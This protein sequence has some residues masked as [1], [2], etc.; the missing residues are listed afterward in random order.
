M[1]NPRIFHID[2]SR[3]WRGGQR[4]VAYLMTELKKSNLW[5]HLVC[6]PGSKLAEFCKTMQLSFSEILM[7]GE[8][9]FISAYKISKL[10]IKFEA[11]ILHVHTAHGLSIGLLSKLFYPK[12]KLIYTK[13][14]AYQMK[15]N[16]MSAFKYRN[17]YLNK[18]VCISEYIRNSMKDQGINEEK[19][20]VIPSGIILPEVQP[21]DKSAFK[22]KYSI[23]QN[24]FI[25][26][27]I[28]SLE[29]NKGY[30]NL[31]NAAQYVLNHDKDI[32][33]LALGKG[34][35]EAELRKKVN[36]MGLS[37]HF[38]FLGFQEDTLSFLHISD[39]FVLPSRE[40]GLG[41]SILDAQA[42]GVPVIATK[43]GGIPEL[44][45][46]NVNGILVAV[47]DSIQLAKKI[48]EL[49]QNP[50]LMQKLSDAARI[51]VQKFSIHK[52]IESYIDLYHFL[53]K[54]N[55]LSL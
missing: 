5:T 38:H 26:T 20:L 1:D 15:N 29:K 55:P 9:D 8:L 18:I 33:F 40:E 14:V 13:R 17:S 41:S 30:I 42:V 28:A 11:H 4:Q 22:M 16:V 7:R 19:L 35:H 12:I 47:D 54:T 52:T 27:T 24:S 43:T 48:L 39:L 45:E 23:P 21:L 2:T 44:I 49:K 6:Q 53:M 46:H 36:N 32:H 3:T 50:Q 37:D 51:S 10:L 31:I 34:K 25:I